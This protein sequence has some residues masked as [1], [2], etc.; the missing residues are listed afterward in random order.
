M[1][2]YA[3]RVGSFFVQNQGEFKMNQELTKS[4]DAL[5][6]QVHFQI[7]QNN[8][9]RTKLSPDSQSI[10]FISM[11]QM[12]TFFYDLSL[13]KDLFSYFKDQIFTQ[14]NHLSREAEYLIRAIE[15]EQ[16]SNILRQSEFSLRNRI[17]IELIR[18]FQINT[19][20]SDAIKKFAE[21]FSEVFDGLKFNRLKKELRQY[22]K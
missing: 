5:K 12:K 14:F 19:K 17:Q 21:R 11:E 3:D 1:P 6:K 16:L 10:D 15:N 18:L 8:I 9:F 20:D 22:Y 4:L 7:Q 13:L 2:W